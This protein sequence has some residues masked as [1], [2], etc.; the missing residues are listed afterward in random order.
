MKYNV[1]CCVMNDYILHVSG[2][3]EGKKNDLVAI[4]E[5]DIFDH[6]QE[7]VGSIELI[8]GKNH[9]RPWIQRKFHICDQRV[10]S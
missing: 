10:N 9:G 8:L 7:D 4:E 1:F 3:Y 6:L 2:P 5:T